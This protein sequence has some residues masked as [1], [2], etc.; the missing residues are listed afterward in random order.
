MD[1]TQAL[2]VLRNIGKRKQ[3]DLLRACNALACEWHD[4]AV[5]RQ[6]LEGGLEML[7]LEV[8]RVHRDKSSFCRASLASLAYAYA[9][10]K[11]W[12]ISNPL[13]V[14]TSAA[15]AA[16][17]HFR[18]EVVAEATCR[19]LRRLSAH[20]NCLS[21][22]VAERAGSLLVDM[23]MHHRGKLES[24]FEYAAL[25]A[26]TQLARCSDGAMQLLDSGLVASLKPA[27]ELT[28]YD[29]NIEEYLAKLLATVAVHPEARCTMIEQGVCAI[30]FRVLS[31]DSK[32]AGVPA[33]YEVLDNLSEEPAALE[34]LTAPA[35]LSTLLRVFREARYPAG[36]KPA[37]LSELKPPSRTAP[38]PRGHVRRLA[39]CSALGKL[40]KAT[41]GAH[42]AAL[43]RGVGSGT[44]VTGAAAAGAAAGAAAAG[45]AADSN[46]AS[47]GST[48]AARL[49]ASLSHTWAVRALSDALAAHLHD[50]EFVQSIC[51]ALCVPLT[52]PLPEEAVELYRT[53]II[54]SALWAHRHA[55]ASPAAAVAVSELIECI[56]R[57]T[58]PAGPL[59][60]SGLAAALVT[61]PTVEAL[62]NIITGSRPAAGDRS[63]AQT[64]SLAHAV[65]KASIAL[66]EL[67]HV[68]FPT[69][70]T[71][72]Q[73]ICHLAV[74]ACPGDLELCRAVCSAFERF[75]EPDADG[76]TPVAL[77]VRAVAHVCCDSL[78]RH[79]SDRTVSC[80]VA[81]VLERLLR[82]DEK[83]FPTGVR[84]ALGTDTA[85]G[86]VAVTLRVMS[87][88]TDMLTT[89]IDCR[90]TVISTLSLL[91]MLLPF[92]RGR[93]H[94]ASLR[95]H[96]GPSRI[97]VAA[98]HV[99][100]HHGHDGSIAATACQ[101][102][103]EADFCR[104]AVALPA[105]MEHELLKVVHL[106]A[107]SE[108]N[109][110][111]V[112]N[113][114]LR[115]ARTEE[116]LRRLVTAGVI[117][118]VISTAERHVEEVGAALSACEVLAA[119]LGRSE[120]F[121]LLEALLPRACSLAVTVL[122][123]HVH[124][125]CDSKVQPASS[126][127]PGCRACDARSGA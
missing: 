2:I 93:W 102:A 15:A 71:Q 28:E 20:D 87:A 81:G 69:T 127:L 62:D 124:R 115:F 70:D 39:V 61:G 13:V 5:G 18:E 82:L 117:D 63:L 27:V 35:C 67:R 78:E 74:E 66:L 44:A 122:R 65:S 121:M 104:L 45:A 68:A 106:H 4:D 41:T 99:L 17:A 26:M 54:P 21:Q 72:L 111:A 95:A 36:P 52:L 88:L 118:A 80:S 47:A 37:E 112:C 49:T 24:E 103:A 76:V 84:T 16:R 116:P 83:C 42:T 12:R 120:H 8:L 46:L 105:G 79:S 57:A 64:R 53:A 86:A 50:A 75:T 109:F 43:A 123:T 19:V 55:P 56:A 1:P 114:L 85:S 89:H 90:Q 30:V 97:V 60:S 51:A 3:I 38:R 98:L 32:C 77:Y 101:L 34:T 92:A 96:S 40:A 25:P 94:V 113:A 73:W 107:L 108:E 48:P 10:T 59:F 14:V 22:L 119:A 11:D 6:L 31:E 125:A 7:L 100:L 9:C 58:S 29:S 23:L 33:W 91:K 110:T 126:G